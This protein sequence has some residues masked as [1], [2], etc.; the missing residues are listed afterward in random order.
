MDLTVQDNSY[1]VVQELK[2]KLL[3]LL[4][5]S[6]ARSPGEDGVGRNGVSQYCWDFCMCDCLSVSHLRGG[7]SPST[8][9]PTIWTWRFVIVWWLL[10]SFLLLYLFIG[11]WH[12]RIWTLNVL[13]R[14]IPHK[15]YR[16]EVKNVYG[17]QNFVST[18]YEESDSLLFF[19]CLY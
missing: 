9:M 6:Q 10:A 18:R 17:W 4:M 14:T 16:C 3:L 8:G 2:L 11:I 19:L 15:L 12:N 5:Y 1:D 13:Y 7:H